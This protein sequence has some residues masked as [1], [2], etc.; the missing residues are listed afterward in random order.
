MDVEVTA[1]GD[2]SKRVRQLARRKVGELDRYV[3]GPVIGSARVVLTQESNP[4]IELAA[5]AE[6]DVDV[7][8]HLV[9]ARVAAPSMESAVDQLAEHLRRQLRRFVEQMVTRGRAPAEPPPGEWS[10]GSWSPRRPERFPRPPEERELVR[11]KTF[12][13][14]PTTAVEAVLEMQTL[15]HDFFLF[16]DSDT[17]ADAVV[18]RRDDGRI[19]V[20]E[21][22]AVEPTAAPGP[23]WER[24]R[25]SEP[26]ELE[27]AVAEMDELEHR[28]LFFENAST[29]R[30]N[31]VYMRHDGHYGLIEPAP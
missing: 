12:A 29:G 27:R 20:I 18:Y 10:H 31:V 7:A 30:G 25:L 28:F 11:R 9:R 6:A 8:G 24:S 4:S 26:I 2:I 13:M 21:P 17:G 14:E 5:R 16:R 22:A 23:S 3:K 15:D 19:A 1:K